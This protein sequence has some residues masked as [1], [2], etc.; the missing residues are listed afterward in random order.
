MAKLIVSGILE[1]VEF[2]K[3]G[4]FTN[5]DGVLIKFGAS[6]SLQLSQIV[7]IDKQGIS[8][9][10]KRSFKIKIN[11]TDDDIE[12]LVAKYNQLIGQT[13]QS[14]FIPV[15][16]QVFVAYGEVKVVK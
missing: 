12:A 6:V 11:T 10:A 5:K 4:S 2:G 8:T 13:I 3:S 15:D 16:G 1:G 9:K 7:N 14:S